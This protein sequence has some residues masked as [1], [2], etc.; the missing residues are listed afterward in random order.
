MS[1][2]M[3][4]QQ[5]SH[6]SLEPGRCPDAMPGA[7]DAG[8]ARQMDLAV[9]GQALIEGVMMR[10][11]TRWAAAARTPDGGITHTG[12]PVPVWARRTDGIPV[13]RG[14]MA[15]VETILV[16][17]RSLRW[18]A[19]VSSGEDDETNTTALALTTVLTLVLFTAVFAVVPA[20]IARAVPGDSSIVFG[21][22]EG[23]AR[24][25]LFLGLSL[26]HISEPTRRH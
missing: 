9:G 25:G 26:I 12:G 23:L 22:V 10:G 5:D 20:A 18:S 24:L 4:E 1:D 6:S 3:P 11:P 8:E 19:A 13:V 14:A 2:S 16:G 17:L 15:M 21:L 7:I